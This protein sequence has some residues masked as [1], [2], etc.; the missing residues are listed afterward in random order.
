[1]KSGRIEDYVTTIPDFPKK[2]VMFRDVTTVIEDPDG[3]RL[4]VDRMAE[5]LDG[6]GFD[7]IAGL[8]ARGFIFGAALACRFGTGFVAIRKKGKLPRETVSESYELEYGTAEIEVHTDSV[9]PGDRVV[10]VDD[11]LATGGTASAACRLVERLGGKVAKV[12]FLME[13][14]GLRGREKLEGYDVES[15]VSYEG[16]R[17]PCTQ[18]P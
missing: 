5:M 15:A 16:N 18:T 4:A 14:K 12:C 6:V 17:R 7:S 3:L 11:L 2:G 1:M 8:E 9:K 13:L 10:V